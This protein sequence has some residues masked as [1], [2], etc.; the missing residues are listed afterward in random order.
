MGE[1]C[2]DEESLI[3]VWSSIGA[4][5][6]ADSSIVGMW[7]GSDYAFKSGLFRRGL[8][9]ARKLA[10]TGIGVDGTRSAPERVA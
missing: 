3:F 5:S 2:V 8:G 9:G 10:G 7:G 6:P 1:G 4:Y